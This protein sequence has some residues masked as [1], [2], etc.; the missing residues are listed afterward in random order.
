MNT[1]D[2]K[3]A[4]TLTRAAELFHIPLKTG[5]GRGEC[6]FCYSTAGLKVKMD[7]YFHCFRCGASGS[8]IDLLICAGKAK[9]VEESLQLLGEHFDGSA[10]QRR[11]KERTTNYALAFNAYCQ[12]FNE[13]APPQEYARKRGWTTV[14]EKYPIGYS[15]GDGFLLENGL[16]RDMLT[17]LG[18]LSEDGYEVMAGRV[19]FPIRHPYGGVVH[20]QGRSLLSDAKTRWIC[21]KGKPPVTYYLFNSPELLNS[22]HKYIYLTEGVSDCYSLLQIGLPAVACFGINS[23]LTQ[24][25]KLFS[26]FDEVIA[27]LDNDKFAIGHPKAGQYKSWASMVPALIE[28]SYDHKIKIGCLMPPNKPGIKDVNDYMLSIGYDLER[29]C[30]WG[31]SSVRTLP[32]MAGLISSEPWEVLRALKHNRDREVMA[33]VKETIRRLNYDDW[34]PFI[35]DIV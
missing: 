15:P 6:P 12:A 30:E 4:V 33:W 3:D 23:P 13:Y 9:N 2:I 35:L 20:L 18:L 21:T 32:N 17:S 34:L 29:F 19:V 24:H 14:L 26:K 5:S 31:E 16:D 27:V 11:R 22:D 28:L 7:R 8:V 10:M 1:E 25:G